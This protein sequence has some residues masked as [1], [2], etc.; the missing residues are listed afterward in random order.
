MV[1]HCIKLN[2]AFEQAWKEKHEERKVQDR[3]DF[4]RKGTCIYLIV[5]DG[6]GVFCDC[7]VKFC[8]LFFFFF[9]FN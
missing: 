4:S 8:F 9:F 5:L 3:T 1:K 7:M 6:F 2:R